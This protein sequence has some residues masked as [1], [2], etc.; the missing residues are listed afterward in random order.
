MEQQRRLSKEIWW[1]IPIAMIWL[2][3]FDLENSYEILKEW[4][5]DLSDCRTDLRNHC[6]LYVDEDV[7][8]D[9]RKY[10]GKTDFFC[11]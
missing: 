3:N 6:L 1:M 8:T 4:R 10:I 9:R 11:R 5:L 7:Q 2:K